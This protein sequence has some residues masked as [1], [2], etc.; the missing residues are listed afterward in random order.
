[1]QFG[2]KRKQIGFTIVELLIVIVVIAILAA[3][4]IV[5]Y[6]GVQNRANDSAVQNDL[7]NIAA[8][9][10]SQE[11]VSGTYPTGDAELTAVGFKVSKSAYSRGVNLGGNDWNLVYC[12]PQPAAQ[13]RFALVA[14]SKSGKVFKW[15]GG[16]ISEMPVAQFS[17]GSD[18]ICT[19]AG[20]PIPD[21]YSRDW[22]FNMDV[23][24]DYAG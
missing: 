3:V 18:V 13:Y 5:A 24:Q 19:N 23:W 4:S 16:T 22:F 21:G 17:G 12:W 6:R 11:V 9:I 20:S 15:I 14:Q 7:R 1:M 2:G 10:K 8:K